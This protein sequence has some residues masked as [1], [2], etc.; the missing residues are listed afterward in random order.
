MEPSRKAETLFWEKESGRCN[1]TPILETDYNIAATPPK[2]NAPTRPTVERDDV[3]AAAPDLA[4][5]GA[6][7]LEPE[8][9]AV[10][11]ML[12]VTDWTLVLAQSLLRAKWS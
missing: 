8:P 6:V 12:R 1:E 11:V 3:R 9:E 5:A 10:P 4:P 7:L 2:T